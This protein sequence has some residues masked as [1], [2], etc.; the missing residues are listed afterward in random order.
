MSSNSTSGVGVTGLLGVL[1]IVLPLCHV[2]DWPWQWVLAPFW[3]P[4]AI[5]IVIAVLFA[6]QSN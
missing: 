6:M 3:I 5:A 2:I 4:W 1:F